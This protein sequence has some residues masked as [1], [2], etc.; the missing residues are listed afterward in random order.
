[1]KN[2][3]TQIKRVQMVLKWITGEKLTIDGKYGSKTADACRKAQKILGATVDG[4]FGTQ[5]LRLSKAYKK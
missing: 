3:P 5:T 4:I 1:M 2:Y